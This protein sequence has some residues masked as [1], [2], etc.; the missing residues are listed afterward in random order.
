MAAARIACCNCSSVTV[1]LCGSGGAPAPMQQTVSLP[2]QVL[3]SFKS[4]GENSETGCTVEQCVMAMRMQ[5]ATMES[6]RPVIDSLV[7]EGL[8]YSTIDDDHL[9]ST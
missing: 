5:G 4:Y 2:D 3:E 1:G 9:K 6:V 7:N 8:L